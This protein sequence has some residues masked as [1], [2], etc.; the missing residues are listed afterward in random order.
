MKNSS[1]LKQGYHTYNSN[2][3]NAR[4]KPKNLDISS[5]KYPKGYLP[6]IFIMLVC[7][8]LLIVCFVPLKKQWYDALLISFGISFCLEC[9]WLI[10]RQN[11]GL[12]T[13][14]GIRNIK[15][16][17]ILKKK[18]ISKNILNS[19]NA[20]NNIQNFEDYIL[21]TKIRTK[22][23]RLVF[24]LSFGFHGIVLFSVVIAT[25]IYIY[26]V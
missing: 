13:K 15:D 4:S 22:R 5:Y 25:I 21:F 14:Y 11:F 19:D 7:I 24:W 16:Q 2:S 9:F 10:F 6:A 8:V 18:L 12:Q 23:S 3:A 20:Q 26:A 1:S 17:I